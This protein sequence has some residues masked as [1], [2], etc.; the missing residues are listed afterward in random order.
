[1]KP[2]EH[3][4]IMIWKQA[5]NPHLYLSHA[6]TPINPIN[7]TAAITVLLWPKTQISDFD[8]FISKNIKWRIKMFRVKIQGC[9]VRGPRIAMVIGLMSHTG[10]GKG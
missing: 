3:Y 6:H 9:W 10:I 7:P 1:M 2:A 4:H 8:Q 5:I